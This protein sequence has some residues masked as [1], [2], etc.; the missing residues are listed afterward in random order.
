MAKLL[1]KEKE[2][3]P[4]DKYNFDV[5]S[6]GEN[7][8]K[9]EPISKYPDTDVIYESHDVQ[10]CVNAAQRGVIIEAHTSIIIDKNSGL[11]SKSVGKYFF[12]E[13]GQAPN[14]SYYAAWNGKLYLLSYNVD[15]NAISCI[16]ISNKP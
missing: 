11:S 3:N 9:I 1:N 4:L 15:Y 7:N 10:H 16:S 13:T 12:E 6:T 14:I 8:S 5:G 2:V